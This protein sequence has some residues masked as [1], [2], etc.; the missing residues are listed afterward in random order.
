MKRWSDI[1]QGKSVLGRVKSEEPYGG[2][3]FKL[4]EGTNI[5]KPS[6]AGAEQRGRRV[7]NSL[8][9]LLVKAFGYEME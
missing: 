8:N 3:I 1:I 6:V 4:V 9:S 5:K 7:E 2:G